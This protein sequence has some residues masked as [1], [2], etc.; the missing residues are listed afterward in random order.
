[1]GEFKHTDLRVLEYYP[2]EL[3]CWTRKEIGV[4]DEIGTAAGLIW[5]ALDGSGELSLKD[6]KKRVKVK[7]PV[8]DCAIGWLAREDKIV[9][10]LEK[11]SFRVRLRE[12]KAKSAGAS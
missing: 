3:V 1:L 11:R 7:S 5:H 2:Q 12:Q 8:F 4:Q 6:L 9:I 10:T